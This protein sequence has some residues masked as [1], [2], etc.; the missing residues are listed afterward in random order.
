MYITGDLINQNRFI[1]NGVILL[2]Y[3]ITIIITYILVK[4]F[5]M[6][7]RI[8]IKGKRIYVAKES[9]YLKHSSK[10][11]GIKC[12]IKYSSSMLSS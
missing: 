12:S 7:N 3:T 9:K 11:L 2:K 8:L 6:L 5:V 1:S 10:T 4:I